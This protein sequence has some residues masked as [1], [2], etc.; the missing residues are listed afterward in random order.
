MSVPV[1]YNFFPIPGKTHNHETSLF[2]KKFF[3]VDL[4]T[5]ESLLVDMS[6]GIKLDD[7]LS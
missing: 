3:L 1:P 4:P 6:F 7:F 5:V 2:L